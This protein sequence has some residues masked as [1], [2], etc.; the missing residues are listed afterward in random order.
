MS[1]Q[2][3]VP[4]TATSP[5]PLAAGGHAEQHAST[6]A[7]RWAAWHARGKAHDQAVKRRMMFI[8]PLVV[9]ALVIVVMLLTR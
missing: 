3:V 2:P 7:E 1:R 5:S 6:E 4:V 9:V 8:G